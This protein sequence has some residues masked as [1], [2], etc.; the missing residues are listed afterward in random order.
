MWAFDIY[1]EQ[2][3]IYWYLHTLWG[4]FFKLMVSINH[5]PNKHRVR[6]MNYTYH[7]FSVI[8]FLKYKKMHAENHININK[9]Y[10]VMFKCN[11][12]HM[13]WCAIT[14]AS[15]QVRGTLVPLPS[16]TWVF[17]NGKHSRWSDSVCG[18]L[19]RW[20]SQGRLAWC[21]RTEWKTKGNA[22]LLTQYSSLRKIVDRI[23][24]LRF[25][26]MAHFPVQ[27]L[28]LNNSSQ[29]CKHK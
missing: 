3:I 4:I 25:L 14:G 28:N 22:R 17:W 26:L 10:Q 7:Q 9:L 18:F 24:K 19:V 16:T 1:I 8:N 12:L 27:L 5:N 6:I 23:N 13:D 29:I 2:T 21:V 15:A 11:A 20:C